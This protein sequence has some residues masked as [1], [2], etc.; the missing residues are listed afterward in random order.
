MP[1]MITQLAKK[2]AFVGDWNSATAAA[3][4][5]LLVVV[6]FANLVA[7]LLRNHFEKKRSN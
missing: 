1:L 2:P 3:I 5:V 6:I 7:I 4:L